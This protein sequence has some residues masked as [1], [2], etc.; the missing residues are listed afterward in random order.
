MA[1]I[2]KSNISAARISDPV[3]GTMIDAET[4]ALAVMTRGLA[5]LLGEP[6]PRDAAEEMAAAWGLIDSATPPEVREHRIDFVE[7]MSRRIMRLD[8][9]AETARTADPIRLQ[10]TVRTLRQE[11]ANQ[12]EQVL[13]ILPPEWADILMIALAL[14]TI[15]I[16]DL[17]GID[18]FEQISPG[19]RAAEAQHQAER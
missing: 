8:Q 7:A 11:A 18:W 10:M 16:D 19:L 2:V 3:T 15:M 13:Q 4:A 9:L 12:P 14:A 17:G 5:S 6:T 1:R